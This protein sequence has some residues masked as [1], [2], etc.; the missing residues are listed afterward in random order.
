[1]N[2]VVLSRPD[3][4]NNRFRKSRFQAFKRLVAN[5]I[6]KKNFCRILD[7]GGTLEYWRSFQADL[8][9]SK[10][11]VTLVNLDPDLVDLPGFKSLYCDARSISQFADNSFD[12]VHSNS[13]IEHV[14][15]WNDMAAMA[16]EV[17]RLAPAYFVQTPYFW[18][19]LEPH[20]RTL[21]F[22]WMPE[23]WR[24][25]LLMRRS[26]GFWP[27][28]PNLGSAVTAVQSALLL[29]KRQMQFLFPDARIVPERCF[30][31]TKSLI[32]IREDS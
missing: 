19:P 22:H 17:R 16:G 32:A 26:L 18:F 30:G 3:N 20:A 21:F 11:D 6:A 15:R 2:R 28:Q 12:V 1:M 14:G 7:V 9:W 29:D 10:V 8:D 24:Y 13:V 25:R 31:L 5:A 23:C 4:V 27:Q